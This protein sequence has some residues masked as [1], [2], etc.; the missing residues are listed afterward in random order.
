MPIDV[1]VLPTSMT[2]SMSAPLLDR[3]AR[4]DVDQ[5]PIPR[6]REQDTVVPDVQPHSVGAVGQPHGLAGQR[7]PLEPRGAERG[8][9]A[10][11]PGV[12][13]PGELLEHRGQHRGGRGGAAGDEAQRGRPVGE[14]LGERGLREIDARLSRNLLHQFRLPYVRKSDL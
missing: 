11:P 7:G 12:V 8:E 14:G 10:G 5:P 13:V 4:Y 9:A 6:A 3:S 2:S 1:F